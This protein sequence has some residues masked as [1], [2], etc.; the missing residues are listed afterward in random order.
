MSE[1]NKYK[2]VQLLYEGVSTVISNFDKCQYII[3]RDAE[4][5][6]FVPLYVDALAKDVFNSADTVILTSATIIDHKTFA[7]SLGIDCSQKTDDELR[8]IISSKIGK[9]NPDSNSS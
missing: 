9:Q 1:M 2:H 7:K 8:E 5:V 6:T 4:S 3:E